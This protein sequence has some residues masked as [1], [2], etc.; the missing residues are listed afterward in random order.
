MALR[1]VNDSGGYR[2]TDL[3]SIPTRLH[4]DLQ[5]LSGDDHPQYRDH[6]EIKI[7][8]RYSSGT[9][10]VAVAGTQF[11]TKDELYYFPVYFGDT[12]TIDATAFNVTTA[13]PGSVM[14]VAAFLDNGNF[15]GPGLLLANLGTIGTD[16]TGVKEVV[17][18]SVA[19]SSGTF[20]WIGMSPSDAI[21]VSCTGSEGWA[22]F[23]A[24]SP[25]NQVF[26]CALKDVTTWGAWASSP[27]YK[28]ESFPLPFAMFRV[29]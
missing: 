5:L 13:A 29:V 11:L 9:H 20:F 22:P 23:G 6:W 19:F 17:F 26:A 4:S 3:A 2:V 8:G 14:R 15:T 24:A 25:A 1:K 12:R 18:G 7:S 27:S 16:T 21:E 28:Y 10:N